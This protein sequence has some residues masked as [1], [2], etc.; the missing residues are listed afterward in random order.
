MTKERNHQVLLDIDITKPAIKENTQFDMTE[1]DRE[2]VLVL[3]AIVSAGDEVDAT[4][5]KI[6]A[7]LADAKAR[8][9][10]IFDDGLI[11]LADQLRRLGRTDVEICAVQFNWPEET[12]NVLSTEAFKKFTNQ[13]K[14]KYQ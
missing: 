13:V 6:E 12:V 10:K 3:R 1:F 5:E 8:R 9:R 7:M 2:V 11:I 4:I 14:E